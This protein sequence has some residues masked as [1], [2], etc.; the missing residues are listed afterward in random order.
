MDKIT[1]NAKE[2]SETLGIGLSKTYRLLKSGKIPHIRLDA[3][4]LVPIK[5]LESFLTEKS[6]ESLVR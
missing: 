3:H 6:R 2:L 4:I 1:L 5:D